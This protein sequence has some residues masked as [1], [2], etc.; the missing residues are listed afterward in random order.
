MWRFTADFHTHTRYSHGKGS[1]FDNVE[2]ALKRGLN[3]IGIADHGPANWWNV[4]I[5]SLADFD[6]LIY[7]VTRAREH[8]PEIRILA[9]AEAN[10]ISYDG[11]L[12]LPLDVQ[13]RLD[14]ILVGFHTMII[15]KTWNDG[16]RFIG[17][18]LAARLG[19]KRFQQAMEEH[20]KALVAA[21]RRYKVAIVTHPGLKVAVDSAALG[22]ACAERGTLL[23]INARHGIASV[24]FVRQAVKTQVNFVLSSDAHHPNDVGDLAKAAEAAVRAGLSPERILNVTV[25]KMGNS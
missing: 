7:D 10:V 17:L 24:G 12:D 2:V 11:D 13:Q 4:G 8:Y 15:P 21:V 19:S 18:S 23:E 5:R 1:V 20:T 9:G 16:L 3:T 22:A 25:E 6:R 14:Q